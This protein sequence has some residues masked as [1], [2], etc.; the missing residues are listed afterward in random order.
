[1][2][3][4]ESPSGPTPDR[5]DP[6]ADSYAIYVTAERLQVWQYQHSISAPDG[7]WQLVETFDQA[8]DPKLSVTQATFTAP[9]EDG[10]WVHAKEYDCFLGC[11]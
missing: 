10:Y 7:C 8:D 9:T 11:N 4:T 3:S 2:P 5:T 6:I 1:M